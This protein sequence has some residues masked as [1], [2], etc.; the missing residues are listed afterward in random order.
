M[1]ANT[2]NILMVLLGVLIL[3]GSVYLLNQNNSVEAQPEGDSNVN[4]ISLGSLTFQ[5]SISD[6][7]HSAQAED[8]MIYIY[9]RSDSCGWCKK[10]EA[11]SFNDERIINL[12]NEHFI[13]LS[14][15][16]YKQRSTA[17]DLGIRGTPT[18]IFTTS[19][20][21]E[22]PGTRIPGYA[23]SSRFYTHLNDM[24]QKED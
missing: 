22:I 12:L 17:T 23:D 8:K 14:I 21:Q 18:S 3:S 6:A 16:T 10:F 7:L 15:N 1:N 11:E 20:G 13:L 2:K 9:G 19:D 24:I 4:T 5:T